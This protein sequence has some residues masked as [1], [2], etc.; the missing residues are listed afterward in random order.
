MMLPRR[1]TPSYFAGPPSPAKRSSA[2]LEE[3]IAVRASARV[4]VPLSFR[5]FLLATT[6]S[7]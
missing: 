6:D 5:P 7:S 1:G 4:N 2:Q 3:L